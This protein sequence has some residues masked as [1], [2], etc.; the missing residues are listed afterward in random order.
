MW[1]KRFNG[2]ALSL[3][4]NVKSGTRAVDRLLGQCG[5]RRNQ[6]TLRP[7]RN[8]ARESFLWLHRAKSHKPTEPPKGPFSHKIVNG[9][10]QMHLKRA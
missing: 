4:L 7:V 3:N 1:K 9:G 10:V 5:I 8:I 6:A 2:V